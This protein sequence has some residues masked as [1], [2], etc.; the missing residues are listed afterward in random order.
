M[1]PFGVKDKL[2]KI[3]LNLLF[4]SVKFTPAGGQVLISAETQEPFWIFKVSDTGMGISEK[5]MPLIFNRFWQ[6][7]AS[8]QRKYQGTGIGLALVK[9]LVEAQGGAVTVES[10]LNKGTTM[11]VTLPSSVS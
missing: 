3:I 11:T 4:N 8:A 9:E 10:Q 7:D 1:F 5:D 6:A 2:E